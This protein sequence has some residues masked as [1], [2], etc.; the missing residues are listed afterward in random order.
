MKLGWLSMFVAMSTISA[1]VSDRTGYC[2]K[3]NSDDDIR[4]GFVDGDMARPC[5][6]N[7]AIK[8]GDTKG[9][10]CQQ[11]EKTDT[12]CCDDAPNN[13]FCW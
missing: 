7:Y 5:K 13:P 2:Y 3:R 6:C 1:V 12:V 8:K 4:E 10:V 9:E 11:Y